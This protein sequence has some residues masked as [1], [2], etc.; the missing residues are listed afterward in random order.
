[1]SYEV[2]VSEQGLGSGRKLEKIATMHTWLFV[3]ICKD[4]VEL[5]GCWD[6]VKRKIIRS[7]CVK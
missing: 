7:E 6:W 1:M 5:D 2:E 4:R 3:I